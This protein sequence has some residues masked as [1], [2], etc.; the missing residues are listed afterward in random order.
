MN[1]TWKASFAAL[2][3]IAAAATALLPV[4]AG[5][6]GGRLASESGDATPV[7]SR[8][9]LRLQ[10]DEARIL[11]TRAD[12]ESLA[13]QKL[14]ADDPL[15]QVVLRLEQENAAYRYREAIRQQQ[16]DMPIKL[17]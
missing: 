9:I 6:A 4:A 8:Y 17:E 10:R 16:V 5:A 1:R 7:A 12:T 3:T 15:A 2:L 13:A 11:A 14:P